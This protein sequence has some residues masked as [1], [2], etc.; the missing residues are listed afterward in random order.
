MRTQVHEDKK[1]VLV[2]TD[3]VVTP[4]APISLP[5]LVVGSPR[6]GEDSPLPALA[7]LAR[8]VAAIQPTQPDPVPDPKPV[9][10]STR[11]DPVPR[12][13]PVAP[14]AVHVPR[15]VIHSRPSESFD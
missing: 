13:R 15:V 5:V 7:L 12:P 2:E 11:S 10:Q 3:G 14:A 9:A 4:P 6:T 1:I 8:G